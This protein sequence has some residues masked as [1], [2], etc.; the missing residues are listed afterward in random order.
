MR[1]RNLAAAVALA[2]A[3]GSLDAQRSTLERIVKQT[4]L[5]NGLR[6]VVVENHAVPIATAE[7]VIRGGAATQ[8]PD[9][10]G[11]P[12]LFEHMLFRGFGQGGEDGFRQRTSRL[13]AG[14]NGTTSAE[15]VTYY[16]VAP[17]SATNEII[18]L[19]AT[20]MLR[21]HFTDDGLKTER[22]IVFGE[23]QRRLSD[24]RALLHTEM[25]RRLWGPSFHRKNTLGETVPLLSVNPKRLR[26]IFS[27]WYV[28]GN[29]LLVV[30]GDVDATKVFAKATEEFGGWKPGPDPFSLEPVPPM[31]PLPRS[32]AFVMS[33]DIPEI[34]LMVKWQGP[35]VAR[36][37]K[38]TYAADV[39]SDIANDERSVFQ[40][41]LV[42][43]GFFSR[44]S[45]G[46]LTLAHTGEIVFTGTTTM[47]KIEAALTALAS[48]LQSMTSPG[49]FSDDDIA[50]AKKQRAVRNALA[51]EESANL[52]HTIGHWWAVAS[53]DYYLDYEDNMATQTRDDLSRF[54]STYIVG[55]PFIVGAL[56]NEKDA[57]AL[58]TTLEEY[59][60]F[61]KDLEPSVTA[62]PTSAP[63]QG[64][65][66]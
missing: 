24:P 15:A 47:P 11:V 35:S 31:T 10:Q 20:L 48:E 58:Q 41:R 60:R 5:P 21:G 65:K 51:M 1:L 63:A 27:R 17:S 64:V 61:V 9:D 32:E 52:A 26:E 44:A 6:V 34:T 18:D 50:I 38:A 12:H 39:V 3:A 55:K 14:Y 49:Y 30:T 46:Y 37:T 42:H 29:A 62:S 56:A 43:S 45:L 36:D 7:I 54:M 28:P 66:P 59:L 16:L 8:T 53:L 13:H 57:A 19:L 2:G 40:E 23:L 22:N 4:V 25:Q 33:G